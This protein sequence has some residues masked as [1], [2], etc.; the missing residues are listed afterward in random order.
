MP[1]F[2]F[3]FLPVTSDGR[4]Q[5][6]L[7]QGLLE[8]LERGELPAAPQ[9]A[10]LTVQMR[11]YQLQSLQFMLDCERGEG[12]FRRF[13]WLPVGAGWPVALGPRTVL[14]RCWQG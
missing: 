14:A 6:R 1:R 5:P 12:G 10:G 4:P 8:V 7:S 11:P 2:L 3:S 9:P 13:F